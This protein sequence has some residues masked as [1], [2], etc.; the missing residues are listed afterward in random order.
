MDSGRFRPPESRSHSRSGQPPAVSP[1]RNGENAS[2]NVPGDRIQTSLRRPI[3][4]TTFSAG[5]RAAQIEFARVIRYV[6]RTT[7][8]TRETARDEKRDRFA[9]A[10]LFVCPETVETIFSEFEGDG[11][12]RRSMFARSLFLIGSDSNSSSNSNYSSIY[13]N[14]IKDSRSIFKRK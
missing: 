6:E 13:L 5:C 7:D 1:S 11:E 4:G 10:H 12:K 8:R 9:G 14:D 3:R 2:G